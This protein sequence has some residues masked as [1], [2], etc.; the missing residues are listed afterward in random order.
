MDK[1]EL[2]KAYMKSRQALHAGELEDLSTR[3]ASNFFSLDL[4]AVR[5]LHLYYPIAGKQEIDSLLI[6]N[7]LRKDYRHIQLVLP[8]SDLTNCTL[9][10]ICWEESTPL[11]MNEWGITEPGNGREISP[12]LIDLIVI[13]LLACDKEGNR[14][15]YGKGFYDRFLT[16]CRP[17]ALKVGLSYFEPQESIIAHESHD[18]PLDI[19]I[20]PDRIWNFKHPTLQGPGNDLNE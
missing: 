4:H 20:T 9:K 17:E 10:H 1:K 5:Y 15:G 6:S 2:R 13:P 3:I 11:A 19:C 7:R 16:S 8:K 18:I 12:E 14:L